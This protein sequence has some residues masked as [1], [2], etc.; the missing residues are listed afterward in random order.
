MESLVIVDEV[1]REVRCLVGGIEVSP[2]ALA[3]DT[4][5]NAQ[6][7][8][9]FLADDHTLDNY[10]WAQ[11]QPSLIDRQ[12]YQTWEKRGSKDMAIRANERAKKILAEHEVAPLP[13]AAEAMIEEILKARAATLAA[14]S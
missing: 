11:W 1:I 2:R 10:N 7:G 5:H 9:G 8:G 14:A 6:P 4:I 12:R 3:R 13:D